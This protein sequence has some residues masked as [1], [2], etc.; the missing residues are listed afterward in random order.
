MTDLDPATRIALAALVWAALIVIVYRTTLLSKHRSAGLPLAFVLATTLFHCGGLVHLSS[1]YDHN[2]NRY[3]LSWNYTRETV[4]YGIEASMVGILGIV[5]GIKLAN[6]GLA[7][8]GFAQS[9]PQQLLLSSSRFLIGVS[10]GVILLG[11]LAR[12]TVASLP[13]VGAVLW[14]FNSLLLLGICGLVLHFSLLR[15]TRNVVLATFCGACAVIGI[16][17]FTIA[18]LGDS[19]SGAIIVVAFSLMLFRP[20][21]PSMLKGL[22]SLVAVGYLILLAAVGWLDIRSE[23]RSAVWSNAS[24]SDRIDAFVSAASAVKVFDPTHQDHLE[25][26]DMRM[27]HNVTVGKTVELLTNTPSLSA[28]GETLLLA[29]FGWIPRAL[30]P[31]KPERG[32]S[33]MVALYTGQKLTVTSTFGTG[34]IFEFFINFGWWGV[35]FG[36]TL[37]GFV[38]RFLDIRSARIFADGNLVRSGPYFAAGVAMV[39]PMNNLFFIVNGAITAAIAGG[40]AIHLARHLLGTQVKVVEALPRRRRV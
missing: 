11:M 1:T 20:T 37:Y 30:W 35:F 24:L 32:G 9:A 14:G 22:I 29:V 12:D 8:G 16:Q 31:D 27:N 38:L 21:F 40:I 2:L 3:L 19:T 28:N 25:W 6:L 18:I 17:M 10:A 5:M 15:Q 13:G 23:V 26:L 33:E 36:C 39:A 34:P 7:N 4:A